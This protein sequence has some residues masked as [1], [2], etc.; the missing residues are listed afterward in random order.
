MRGFSSNEPFTKAAGKTYRPP[1]QKLLPPFSI[2]FTKEERK[3]LNR[4]SGK[5]ALS[6][7]IRLKLFGKAVVP[8]K[9]QYR[10]KQR[11]PRMDHEVI[12]K[13]LGTL[14]QSELA[15]SLI[16][17]AM[18]AQ[19]GSLPVTPELE[20]K[21]QLACDDIHQMRISLVTSLG[22]KPEGHS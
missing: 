2:R 12:A 14:G 20:E 16:A 4:D 18:A 17:I 9:A 7:Y 10:N 19:S 5:M 22:I 8:R 6:A 1:R 15:T 21:L 3:R 11:Q 13:L